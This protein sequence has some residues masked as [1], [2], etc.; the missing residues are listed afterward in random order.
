MEGYKRIESII[1][2]RILRNKGI[3]AF[4]ALFLLNVAGWYIV[5][6]SPLFETGML[7]SFVSLLYLLF[8]YKGYWLKRNTSFNIKYLLNI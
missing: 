2:L 6:P 5:E 7:V 4:I 8:D 1:K 3:G